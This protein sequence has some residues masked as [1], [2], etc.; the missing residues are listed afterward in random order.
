MHLENPITSF[1]VERDG[2]KI[3][4]VF[5]FNGEN[6]ERSE[7]R[8]DDI[9]SICQVGATIDRAVTMFDEM[10]ERYETIDDRF[11]FI[12]NLMPE[13]YEGEITIEDLETGRFN[14]DPKIN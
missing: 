9:D 1:Y 2:D 3:S 8:F 10:L 4:F 14:P 11:N 7:F 5:T 6:A 13:H 12:I